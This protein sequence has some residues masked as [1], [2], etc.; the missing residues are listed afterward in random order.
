[1][2]NIRQWVISIG[3][4]A[5]VVSLYFNTVQ[6]HTNQW[7]RA[8]ANQDLT[9]GLGSIYQQHGSPS[10]TPLAYEGIGRLRSAWVSLPTVH[11][12]GGLAAYFE[13][14]YTALSSNN[15]TN[16]TMRRHYED[17]MSA[18]KQSTVILGSTDY[19]YMSDKQ[20]QE[21]VDVIYK[22]MTVEER[23]QYLSPQG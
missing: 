3:V 16:P 11:G 12:I 1:M 6:Y 2:K 19:R 9:L 7:F 13:H 15:G 18:A 17:V 4:I 14:V 10:A 22:E 8:Y 21:A 23:N 20:L 5:L